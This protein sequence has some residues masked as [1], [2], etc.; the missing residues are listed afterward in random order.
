MHILY[1]D[2]Y[3]VNHFNIPKKSGEYYVSVTKYK[4]ENHIWS[5]CQLQICV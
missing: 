1:Y 4:L 3:L 5:V 2:F